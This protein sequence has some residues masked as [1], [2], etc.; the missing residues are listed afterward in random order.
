MTIVVE[1]IEC[2]HLCG[3]KYIICDK[4]GSDTIWLNAFLQTWDSDW[5]RRHYKWHQ[6][7][8]RSGQR[9]IVNRRR[10]LLLIRHGHYNE[11]G[12]DDEAR[13]LTGLGQRQ[14]RALGLRLAELLAERHVSP[15]QVKAV[16]S[17]MHRAKQTLALAFE[18]AAAAHLDL[19][20]GKRLS[21]DSLLNE[22]F[23]IPCEPPT[24]SFRSGA[25]IYKDHARIEAAFRRYVN[26]PKAA[27]TKE[28]DD[29][30]DTEEQG[31]DEYLLIFGHSNVIRYFVCVALQ[32]PPEAWLRFSLDHTSITWITIC[33]D[34]DVYLSRYVH[35]TTQQ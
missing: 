9:R 33:S 15:R 4:Y 19:P 23:P 7:Q 2:R 31:E 10:H 12:A 13:C 1:A 25:R 29:R 28:G 35:E 17:G 24:G 16:S 8:S 6:A 14:A 21:A 34:G 11:A 30:A 32:L 20:C 26:R 5:D 3:T 27:L 18:G 22:G